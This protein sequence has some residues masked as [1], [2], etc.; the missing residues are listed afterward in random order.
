M[1]TKAIKIQRWWR[2]DLTGCTK[3]GITIPRDKS[4]Y[5]FN[6]CT[7]CYHDKHDD[8]CEICQEG[9]THEWDPYLLKKLERRYS[10]IESLED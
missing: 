3:C 9:G 7:I 10:D 2:N 5:Q 4:I 8:I 6:K 1:N